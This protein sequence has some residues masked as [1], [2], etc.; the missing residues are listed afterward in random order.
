MRPTLWELDSQTEK[1]GNLFISVMSRF[2]DFQRHCA[3]SALQIS[4]NHSATIFFC[5]NEA[6]VNCGTLNATSLIWLKSHKPN[7][8]DCEQLLILIYVSSIIYYSNLGQFGSFRMSQS[9]D[10]PRYLGDFYYRG[11]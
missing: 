4:K 1:G 3:I 6:C 5:K 7:N 10:G 8:V 11:H 9:V 2:H